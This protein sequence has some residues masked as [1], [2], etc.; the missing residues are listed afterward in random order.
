M[1]G[2]RL[3]HD[4]IHIW[5]PRFGSKH[6]PKIQDHVFIYESIDPIRY[7]HKNGCAGCLFSGI[8]LGW[9]L[10]GPLIAV[11]NVDNTNLSVFKNI[12][13]YICVWKLFDYQLK[14][15]ENML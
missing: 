13:M 11:V 14:K 3:I 2:L 6:F 12:C 8:G 5:I 10:K 9:I 1:I 15:F 4:H 7:G